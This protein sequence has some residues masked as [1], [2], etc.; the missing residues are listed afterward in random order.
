MAQETEVSKLAGEGDLSE[1][2]QVKE[3]MSIQIRGKNQGHAGL[4]AAGT[5]GM[6]PWDAVTS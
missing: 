2:S 1:G 5:H 6:G 3:E 4:S